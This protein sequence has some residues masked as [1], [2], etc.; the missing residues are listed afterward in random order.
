M[1][2]FQRTPDTLFALIDQ[3]VV[4]LH[5]ERG[6]CFG[7]EKVSADVWDMLEHPVGIDELCSRLMDRY[8]V[9]ADQCR[10][11]VEQLIGQMVEEG[12]VR[13]VA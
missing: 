2:K 1:T 7:M 6:T 5:V 10:S 8:S 4:A 12:I 13:P 9:G 3:D 11:E